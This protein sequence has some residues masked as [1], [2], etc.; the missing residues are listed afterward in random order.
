MPTKGRNNLLKKIKRTQRTR[1]VKKQEQ[2]KYKQQ[3]NKKQQGGKSPSCLVKPDVSRYVD[4]SCHTANLHNTNPEVDYSLITDTGMSGG[5]CPPNVKPMTFKNYL[6]DVA[7]RLGG[8]VDSVSKGDLEQ[9]MAGADGHPTG[10][11]SGAGYSTNPEQ[12]IAGM[13][14]YDKYDD[15]C[16][17]AL[18]KNKLVE[19]G[20][21]GA[22]CGNQMGGGWNIFSRRGKKQAEAERQAKAEA[23]RQAE[24]NSINKEYNLILNAKKEE[25]KN[26]KNLLV[27]EEKK[28][29]TEDL[30]EAARQDLNDSFTFGSYGEYYKNLVL[31]PIKDLEEEIKKENNNL[32]IIE[33]A[34]TPQKKMRIIRKYNE[35]EREKKEK[36]E[37]ARKQA[38]LDKYYGGGKNKKRRTQKRNNSKK[39]KSSNKP[40]S[41]KNKKSKSK[42]NDKKQK[43]GSRPADFPDESHSGLNSDFDPMGKGKDF[44]GKQPFWGAK[45]R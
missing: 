13:P 25:I 19:G 34:N 21:A 12:Q 18:V 44:E 30:K 7:G 5:A 28:D 36:E 33:S 43:G 41:Q 29:R 20:K 32:I 22:I 24:E 27:V 40:K 6:Q 38:E 39:S 14:V 35:E 8:D 2:T 17:P 26:L 9:Q 23:E 42:R 31:K 15:C 3:K 11:Q 16:Q 37:A 10:A 4:N 45:T 1:K